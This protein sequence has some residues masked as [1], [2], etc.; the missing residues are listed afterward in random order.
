MIEAIGN[1]GDTEGAFDLIHQIQDDDQ[2]CGAINSV[3]YCS[4][5]KGFTRE[6]KIDR[7]W[8]VYEEM[9]ARGVELSII[10][11]NTLID[12]CARCGRMDG[13]PKILED[14]KT[15]SIKPNVI[16]YSTMI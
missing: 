11:Y 5:L 15:Y 6:R 7:A 12:A 13:L 3:I 9:K 1:T 14:M 8:E 4:V 10:S 16:T 2:C